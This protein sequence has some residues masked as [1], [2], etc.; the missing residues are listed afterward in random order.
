M[1]NLED[2]EGYKFLELLHDNWDK[3]IVGE[4]LAREIIFAIGFGGCLC[5]I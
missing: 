1:V 3:R 5:L 4:I 2:L